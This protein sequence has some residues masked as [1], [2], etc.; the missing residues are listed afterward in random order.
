[1]CFSLPKQSQRSR[2]ILQNSSK[3]VSTC[4]SLRL[5]CFRAE[6]PVLQ[7]NYMRLIYTFSA[8]RFGVCMGRGEGGG[9][10]CL[11]T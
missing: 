7:L 4:R 3:D 1:M 5:F 2:F 6:K 10:S 11:A 8:G 9:G